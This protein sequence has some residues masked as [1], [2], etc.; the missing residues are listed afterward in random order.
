MLLLSSLT[1]KLD[2]NVLKVS[3]YYLPKNERDIDGLIRWTI[4]HLSDSPS[5]GV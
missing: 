1:G 3:F 2:D 4:R 5:D